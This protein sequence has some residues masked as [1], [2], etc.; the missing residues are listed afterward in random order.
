M[1]L[2]NRSTRSAADETR[3]T[4][5]DA[6]GTETPGRRFGRRFL[7]RGLLLLGTAVGVR[8]AVAVLR[9]RRRPKREFTEIELDADPAE[10]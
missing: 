4:P 2:S 9:R 8:V 7:R 10:Q 1:P 3:E 5:A 6:D